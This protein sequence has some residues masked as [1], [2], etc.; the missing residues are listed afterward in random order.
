VG[1]VERCVELIL[2]LGSRCE[3]L[4]ERCERLEERVRRLEE[5][6]RSSSRNSSQ[7]PSSDPPKTPGYAVQSKS[8]S[9]FRAGKAAWRMRVRAPE[10]GQLWA[11][12][13]CPS[14]PPFLALVK[15]LSLVSARAGS[16]SFGAFIGALVECDE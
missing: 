3:Q 9:V 16:P 15:G 1:V 10:A 6:T 13:S 4:A 8:S 7:P 5:Q 14:R 12:C 2:E 11:T